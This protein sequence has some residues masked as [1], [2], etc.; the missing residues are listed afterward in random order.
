M[1]I[2]TNVT[3]Y[4]RSTRIRIYGIVSFP[5]FTAIVE[6]VE[7]GDEHCWEGALAFG[8][9]WLWS[10]ALLLGGDNSG[11]AAIHV[12]FAVTDLVN[13]RP[14]DRVLARSY[15]SRDGVLEV[16]SA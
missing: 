16:R 8:V 11:G 3:V 2:D 14:S 7:I 5:R 10:V 15:A 13:P 6:T 1:K 4:D 9:F 12:E